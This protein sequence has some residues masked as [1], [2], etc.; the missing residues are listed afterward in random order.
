MNEQVTSSL[1]C[2]LFGVC[3]VSTKQLAIRCIG[4]Q[5]TLML[6]RILFIFVSIGRQP[7]IPIGKTDD[8]SWP[9]VVFLCSF[10]SFVLL[11]FTLFLFSILKRCSPYVFFYYCQRKQFSGM[12]TRCINLWDTISIYSKHGKV[13]MICY[14]WFRNS[15]GSKFETTLQKNPI[16][17]FFVTIW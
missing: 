15:N 9:L 10:S 8:W 13:L 4:E 14:W 12:P 3:L 2:A 1:R 11:F 7:V 16:W 6:A 17:L 5:L